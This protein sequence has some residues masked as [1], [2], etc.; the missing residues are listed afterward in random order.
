MKRVRAFTLLELLVVIAIITILAALLFPLLGRARD[1]AKGAVCLNNLRQWGVALVLYAA[2]NR[3]YLPADGFASPTLPG[4]FKTGWYVQLPEVIHAPSYVDMPWRTNPLVDLGKSVWIC[5][6]N[7]RRSDSSS[8]TNILF[9][10]CVNGL[11]NGTGSSGKSLPLGA[12]PRASSVVYMFDNKNIPAVHANANS[13]GRFAHTN[14]HQQGAQFLF[15]DGHVAHLHQRQYWNFNLDEGR[16]D[17][18]DVVWIP[19]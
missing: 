5:P 4:H 1:K 2:E 16:T 14:L 17:N 13:P 19:Q 11:V 7:P 8:Q 6:S 3:S 12:V 18:S 10:Y 9:H 15:L